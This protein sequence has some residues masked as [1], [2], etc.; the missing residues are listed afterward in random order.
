MDMDAF[1]CCNLMLKNSLIQKAT[2]L[3][4]VALDDN[5]SSWN[6]SG[7]NNAKF[8]ELVYT[9]TEGEIIKIYVFGMSRTKKLIETEIKYVCTTLSP[10]WVHT[11]SVT[12]FE[13]YGIF[14]G[15]GCVELRKQKK[16]PESWNLYNRTASIGG[17]FV[18]EYTGDDES[19]GEQN[20]FI[21][22][23]I[24]RLQTSEK[25]WT[26]YKNSVRTL[27]V[28]PEMY[29]EHALQLLTNKKRYGKF[30]AT[31]TLKTCLFQNTFQRLRVNVI[32]EV[33]VQFYTDASGGF[34]SDH[35]W[36]NQEYNEFYPTVCA[37][38]EFPEWSIKMPQNNKHKRKRVDFDDPIEEIKTFESEVVEIPYN[39]LSVQA[40]LPAQVDWIMLNVV[41]KTKQNKKAFVNDIFCRKEIMEHGLFVNEPYKE[42]LT[43]EQLLCAAVAIAG[44]T[45]CLIACAKET[46][47]EWYIQQCILLEIK[48][49]EERTGI[50]AVFTI[51]Q[52]NEG[53]AQK[54]YSQ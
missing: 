28:D 43:T 29:K 40:R 25:P 34:I 9:R 5:M 15:R 8:I 22:K 54:T 12:M 41:E 27:D 30:H 49:E 35:S 14:M 45:A 10:Q 11:G 53:I 13:K 17:D 44:Y 6:Q 21:Q 38:M 20:T 51:V 26:F 4:K 33:N 31:N 32:K 23:M 18:I 19:L 50:K 1:C 48:E 16:P 3:S 39:D 24:A 37:I 47:N 36:A 52:L 46:V 2:T 42:T 7:T